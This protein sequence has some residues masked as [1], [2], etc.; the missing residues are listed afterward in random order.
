MSTTS[1]WIALRKPVFRGLWLASVLSG[2]CVSAHDMAATWVMNTLTPSPL[3]LSLLSTAASLPFFL[4]TFPAGALADMIDRKTL[5]CRMNLWLALVA[6]GLA[7]LGWLHLLNPWVILAAVFLL[8]VGFACNAPAWTSV[9][10]EVVEKEELPSAVTL[11]GIQMNLS[12]IIGPAI[13]GILLP[14][15]GAN[16]LFALNSVGFLIIVIA[17]TRWHPEAT[18]SKI[19]LKTFLES[20]TGAVRYVH[21]TRGIQVLLVR[22]LL[23]ALLISAIPALLPVVGL[24]ALH[25]SSSSLGLLFTSIA[26]GSLAAAVLV[27][28]LARERYRPNTVTVLASLLLAIVYCLMAYVR[29]LEPFMVVAALGGLSWTLAASELWVAAQQAMP[30]WTRGRMNATQIMIS[31]GGVVLGGIAWG[32]AAT[33]VGLEFTLLIAALLV[34]LHLAIAV[35]LSIDF[36]RS[37]NLEPGPP[38]GMPLPAETP[39]PDDG[40]IAVVADIVIEGQNRKDLAEFIE[41]MLELRLAYL[42]NGASSARLYKNLGEPSVFRMEAVAPTWREYL[43][44][45]TRL[46]KTERQILDRVFNLSAGPKPKVYHYMLINPREGKTLQGL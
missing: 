24:K 8:G 15:I 28:P 43:L 23:F 18:Q 4:L 29:H 2:C 3:L 27:I 10:P 16:A 25:L 38:W 12:G 6:G 22:A 1:I 5:L 41:L 20:L 14:L 11:G 44:L 32:A 7:V 39:D 33:F 45:H 26:I 17:I 13:G 9:I 19:L 36:T 37:L 21:Y 40:P 35:P 34:C 42:R 31:Q 30:D 46:T